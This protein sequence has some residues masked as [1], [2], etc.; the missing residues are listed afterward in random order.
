[1]AGATAAS[2]HALDQLRDEQRELREQ[3]SAVVN[4]HWLQDGPLWA[5]YKLLQVFDRLSLYFCTAPPRAAVIGPAPLDHKGRE[6]DLTL[7]PLDERTVRVEPYPFDAPE[8][9]VGVRAALVADRD[10]ESDDAFRAALAAAEVR[11]LSFRLCADAVP[12][13]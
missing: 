6:V 1:M 7:R 11:A 2:G 8:L 9:T 4:R 5:N 10:Y 3:L 12:S 13:A